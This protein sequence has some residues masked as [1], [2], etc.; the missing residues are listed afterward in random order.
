MGRNKQL[1]GGGG[2]GRQT[3]KCLDPLNCVASV[4]FRKHGT[5]VQIFHMGANMDLEFS[6]GGA[7]PS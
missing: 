1:D 4:A 3:W 5:W 6:G 2:G 7:A